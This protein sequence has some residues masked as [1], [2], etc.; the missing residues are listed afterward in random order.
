MKRIAR[1]Y[2]F[3]GLLAGAIIL[4][5]QITKAIVRNNLALGEMWAPWDWLLPYARIIHINNTGAAFGIF[6]GAGDVFKYLAIVVAAAIIY[7]FP[8]VPRSET[9]L[10]VALGMQLGGAVGNLIDRFVQGHVTDFV[11][12]GTF[13]VWNVADA[14]ITLGVGVL[15]LGMWLE[16]RHQ[17]QAGQTGPL[18][19]DTQN[20]PAAPAD[21]VETAEDEKRL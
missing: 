2:A 12:V 17:R 15:L 11:S 3:L 14:S 13:A 16:E 6:Q 4:V 5:D 10:R 21:A 7:Y 18:V 9:T 8:Q 19:E 1:D 20:E